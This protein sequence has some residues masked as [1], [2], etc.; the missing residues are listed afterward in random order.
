MTGSS[1]VD[2]ASILSGDGNAILVVEDDGELRALMLQLLRRSGFKA[3]GARNAIETGD[4]L[5]ESH[6][7]LVLLDVM[8]PGTSGF[9]LCRQIRAN[10]ALP[11]IML[12]ALSESSDRVIGLE[13]GA[14]DYVVKPADPRELVARIRAVLRRRQGQGSA[15]ERRHEVAA[16]G[17]WALDTRK[18]Q[19]TAPSGERVEV[20]GGEYDLLLAFVER[21][22]RVL[23]RDQILDL[24]R[25]RAFGGLERSVDAQISRLRSKLGKQV[26][27]EDLIKT[28]RGAGYILTAEVT[29]Q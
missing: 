22:Q 2:R 10:S 3:C 8:L 14:D 6:V 29:W 20:T 12:T 24:A 27:G 7:D 25:G 15:P 18:R 9:D 16:F 1:L 26:A 19:L 28:L 5:R 23:S 4:I 11:I 21:P 17:G 13:L